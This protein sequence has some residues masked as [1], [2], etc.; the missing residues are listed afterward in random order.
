MKRLYRL[1]DTAEHANRFARGEEIM[2]STFA[3]CRQIEHGDAGE[4]TLRYESGLIQ[5][6]SQDTAMR[7]VLER[8]GIYVS[9]GARI[10]DLMIKNCSALIVDAN[11][12]LLCL[13]DHI[14]RGMQER[15][16][17]YC[18]EIMNPEAFHALL[19]PRVGELLQRQGFASWSS[20]LSQVVYRERTYVGTDPE[21]DLFFLKPPSLAYER[22]YRLIWQ[23]NTMTAPLQDRAIVTCYAGAPFLKRVT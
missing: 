15:F 19:S 6:H 8:I 7:T 5:G 18:V 14:S 10:E 12:Y 3:R 13:T 23:P 21:P 4:G 20:K 1:F 17:Q 9:P 16:G 22:E 2:L 11:A